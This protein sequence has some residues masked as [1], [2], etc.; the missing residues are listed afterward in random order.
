MKTTRSGSPSS[1]SWDTGS[2]SPQP[3]PTKS[4]SWASNP[5]PVSPSAIPAKLAHG[6]VTWLHPSGHQVHLLSVHSLRAERIPGCE[7]PLQLPHRYFLSR[8]TSRTTSTNLA[9]GSIRFRNPFLSFDKSRNPSPMRLI[10]EFPEIPASEIEDALSAIRPGMS[11]QRTRK[12]MWKKGEEDLE[13][14]EGQPDHHGIVLAGRPYHV[15]SGDQP[16]YSGA[17]QFLRRGRSY[18]GLHLQPQ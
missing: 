15:D 16:R 6:H 4:T 3:P 7:Q 18:R 14:A 12:D 2:S 10:K 13:M 11:W 17:H 1:R 5:S 8:K 9:D